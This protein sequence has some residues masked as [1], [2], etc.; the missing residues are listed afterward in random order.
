MFWIYW[1][2]KIDPT[3][4]RREWLD[5]IVTEFDSENNAI[6]FEAYSKLE[7]EIDGMFACVINP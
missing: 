6:K 1:Y 4:E 5:V 7:T 3:K 2:E